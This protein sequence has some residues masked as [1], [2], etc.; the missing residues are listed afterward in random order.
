MQHLML[1]RE[2]TTYFQEK[3]EKFFG[4]C[5]GQP[6]YID[7]MKGMEQNLASDAIIKP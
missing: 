7:K 1:N 3:C 6:R 2:T 5:N 4:N